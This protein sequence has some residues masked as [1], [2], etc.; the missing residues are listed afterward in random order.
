VAVVEA[1]RVKA[2]SEAEVAYLGRASV[3]RAEATSTAEAARIKDAE[4]QAARPNAEKE[5]ALRAELTVLNPPRRPCP[6][7]LV[8]GLDIDVLSRQ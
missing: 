4:E 8:H 6:W 7:I 5:A 1:A 3:A 2:V